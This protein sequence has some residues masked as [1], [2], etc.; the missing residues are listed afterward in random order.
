MGTQELRDGDAGGLFLLVH[1]LPQGEGVAGVVADLGHH[2]Q[3]DV[4]GL[5]LLLAA[6]GPHVGVLERRVRDL[7]AHVEEVGH[8]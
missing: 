7:S 1:A 5:A 3:A 6:A 8:G 2:Q 4:V